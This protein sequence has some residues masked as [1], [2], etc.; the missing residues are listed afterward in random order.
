MHISKTLNNI[1]DKSERNERSQENR[2]WLKAASNYESTLAN[3]NETKD[4]YNYKTHE[5]EHAECVGIYISKLR[6]KQCT[7]RL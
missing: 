1:N 5:H 3:E 2:K 7:W 6:A 4:T